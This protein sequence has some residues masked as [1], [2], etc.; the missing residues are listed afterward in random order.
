[1]RLVPP[2]VPRPRVSAS[3]SESRDL[4]GLES[5][6]FYFLFCFD[7]LSVP[8]RK[9]PLAAIEALRR[10]LEVT[11]E[12]VGLVLKVT[13]PSLGAVD[14]L[15]E[16]YQRSAELP[17]RLVTRETD[18]DA[19]EHL[20]NACDAY[21]SLHRSEGLGLL[22]IEALYLGKPVVSTNYGGVTDFLD[23]TTGYPIPF[24]LR[25][26]ERDHLP[27][28]AEAVWADPD[29]ASAVEAM[30]RI[31]EHPAEAR[32]RGLRGAHRVEELYGLEAASD[33]FRAEIARVLSTTPSVQ[34][35]A[36]S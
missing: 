16:L 7:V 36:S 19:L 18:R 31:V 32:G 30:R 33:R 11:T 21:L 2:H 22:P 4:L 17:V 15:R 24:R 13:R 35:T 23:E 29:L 34:P 3:R 12:P 9:N 28:P 5:D 1:V 14:L 27:Y 6:R 20:L 8:E 10:L 26:L 25:R